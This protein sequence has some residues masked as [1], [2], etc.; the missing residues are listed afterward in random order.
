MKVKDFKELLDTMDD[1]DEVV[2]LN[3]AAPITAVLPIKN[4]IITKT[5]HTGWDVNKGMDQTTFKSKLLLTFS[6][7]DEQGKDDIRYGY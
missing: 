1:E 3:D 7:H 2:L 6:T 5:P 4:T